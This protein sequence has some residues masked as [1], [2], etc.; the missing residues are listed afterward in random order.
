M[1]IDSFGPITWFKK[2]DDEYGP[3]NGMDWRARWRKRMQ[4]VFESQIMLV[5]EVDGRVLAFASGT[6]DPDARLAYVDLLSVQP[7][8]QGRGYGREM[9]RGMLGHFRTLGAQHVHLEC[10]ADNEA[11]NRLYRSEGFV[12]VARSVRWFRALA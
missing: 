11:G 2:L 4:R 12:E 5:G 10:L 7:G 8:E 1:V 3:L 9:L 6:Y